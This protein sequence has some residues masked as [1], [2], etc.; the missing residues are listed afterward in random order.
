MM[1]MV[2]AING[3]YLA[4]LAEGGE[5]PPTV[6]CETCHRGQK[7]PPQ[8]LAIKLTATAKTK[9]LDAAFDQFSDLKSKYADAGVYDFRDQTLLRVARALGDDKKLDDSL[10]VLQ[11]A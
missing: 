9:G 2:G 3:D 11:K 7:E 6:M 1:K 5:A 10:S 4:K 8:P